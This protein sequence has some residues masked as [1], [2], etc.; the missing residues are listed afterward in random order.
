MDSMRDGTEGYRRRGEQLLNMI[1][2]FLNKEFTEFRNLEGWDV[3]VPSETP[4]QNNSYDCGVFVCYTMKNLV[5]TFSSSP[6]SSFLG[7]LRTLGPPSNSFRSDIWN[8]LQKHRIFD[9]R[10]PDE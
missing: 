2:L 6:S 4:Q 3:S 9:D 1:K 10:D 7:F 8:T 5:K